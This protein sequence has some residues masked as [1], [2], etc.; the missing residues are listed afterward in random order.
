MWNLEK[1]NDYVHLLSSLYNIYINVIFIPFYVGFCLVHDKRKK[2][3]KIIKSFL[4][5]VYNL[6]FKFLRLHNTL[7]LMIIRLSLLL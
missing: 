2:K 4:L 5:F 7:T 1:K 6:A 3:I